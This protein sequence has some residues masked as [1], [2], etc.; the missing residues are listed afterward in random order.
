MADGRR[1]AGGRAARVALREAPLA[2]E[3]RA[4]RPGMS[5][6]R[7][8]PL[9]GQQVTDVIDAALGLL[10]DLG[11]GQATPEFVELV[12]AAG[13]SYDGDRLRF[14]RHLVRST[15]EIAC[16]EF[17]LH[18]FDPARS[19]DIGGDR[20]HFATSGAAVLMLDHDTRRFRPSE[21]QDLYDCARVVDT[22]DNIHVFVRT[23][24]PRDLTDARDIDVNTAYAVMAG[25]TKPVGTSMFHPD[26]VHEVV[27]MYDMALGG[28]GAFRER[29]FAIANNTFVVPPLRFAEESALALAEQAR[30]GF[31]I[32]LLSAGQAGATSPAALAGSLTQ[33]LAECLAALTCVN[34]ISPGH[35]CTIG[36]WPFVSDLRTGAMSG[37][38]GEEAIINACAAQVINALGLPSGVAAGMAD[39]KLPDNQAGHEKGNAVTLAANAG[40]NIVYESAGML[41]SLLS[42]SLEALVIDNDMLG[43]IMRT[44]RGIEITPE[45]LST[46]VIAT[47]VH[48][49]GHFLGHEQTLGIMQSE[50]TYPEVGDRLSP[51]D[52]VDAGATAVH[53][54]AN[55]YVTKVL[56]EHRPNHLDPALDAAIRERFGIRLGRS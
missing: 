30:L 51:D 32:N 15:I 12:T 14:P 1:R 33:A 46:D 16:T 31:P 7:F 34:L 4:V 24:V 38:S 10:A 28:E 11:M 44:V 36:M 37:G 55:D 27:A 13:G 26:H 52:W 48:G 29:P 41:A 53:E 18:G 45:T 2:E 3:A 23:V 54:R 43:A 49:P 17:T 42:C 35:P 21:L 50:Y 40:A 22:L 8:R 47:V 9:T 19:V 25:T 20:V 5:G 39:S 6:G 56:A